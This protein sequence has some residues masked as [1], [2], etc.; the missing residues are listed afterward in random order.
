MFMINGF[1]VLFK[2]FI[3]AGATHYYIIMAIRAVLNGFI[4]RKAKSGIISIKKYFIIKRTSFVFKKKF[5]ITDNKR[6]YY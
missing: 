6:R 1:E 3:I 4:I 2:H 5:V